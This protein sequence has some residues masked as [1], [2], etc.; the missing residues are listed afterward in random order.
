MK[1]GTAYYPDYFPPS[2]WPGDLDRMEAAGIECVR[3]LEFAWSWY[4][5][6]PDRWS[7]EG[8]DDFLDQVLQRK[9]KVCLA[10]P[11]ATPPPWFFEKYPDAR[12]M[13][14]QGQVCWSH[15]HM[16]CWN[17]AAAWDE[18]S[19]TIRTL[20]Q[21]YGD[22]P[23]VWGW[24][25][26]NEPNY[27]EDITAFYDF[28]PH[29]LRDAQRWLRNRYGSIEALNEAWVGAFW[30]QRYN[31]W[32]QVWRT[33]HP[34][35]NPGAFLAF[36][37]WREANM[38][39]FVQKQAALLR[40]ATRSQLIGVN[41]PESGLPTS[42]H[43]G[44][45]YWAQARGLDW[46][47]TDLY[48]ATGNREDDYLSLRYSCDLIRSVQEAVAPGGEFLIAETQ[49][50]PHLRAWKC[51]FAGESWD[52]DFIRGSLRIY[53]ERGATQTWMFMWRPTPGAKEIGMN[54]LQTFEGDDSARTEEIRR[55]VA[56]GGDFDGVAR[57]YRNRPVALLHYSQ[58]SL[59]FLHYFETQNSFLD[60]FDSS[61]RMSQ[62]LRGAHRWLDEE[63]YRIRFVTD[64]E[65]VAGL[66][67][68][69]RLVLPLSPL[70]GRHAQEAVIG[71][72]QGKSK[73]QLWLGPDTGL[74]DQH[75]R[76]LARDE[77]PLWSWLG[78][79]PG[80]LMDMKE[81]VEI[82]E[83][84]CRRFRIFEV[85]GKAEVLARG[86]WRGRWI[87]VQLQC[88]EGVFLH[89]HDWTAPSGAVRGS[90]AMPA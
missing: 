76:W 59:R 84:R 30:S 31:R 85:V 7:W 51:T 86:K 82:G 49:A 41:I 18:A 36:L 78:V 9:M 47:G 80:P 11:T 87:P 12:L 65:L 44:Q 13:S 4:Q 25:I 60:F 35:S 54:G 22:H 56:E 66:P 43:V 89:A 68:A 67:Q 39:E 52:P 10:T 64:E 53:A 3:I 26:D 2:D 24:Q 33:H 20:A 62:V 38:G 27:A 8:L 75:G 29:A 19:K 23:V 42:L 79:E 34:K 57:S 90:Q 72:F 63:G 1:I 71:W 5:P 70:L 15:R 48:T 45:D 21:R 16:T 46:I 6:E 37:Q 88:G 50:G 81:E 17:H 40:E 83:S 14:D 69:E 61:A 28:N 77:R 58:D 74:L 73:R 55:I 32:E